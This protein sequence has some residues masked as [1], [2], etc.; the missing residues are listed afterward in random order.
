M[1]RTT[2]KIS[3]LWTPLALLIGMFSSACVVAAPPEMV[4]VSA[5][6]QP[7]GPAYTFNYSKYL[8]TNNE[9]ARFLNDAEANQ[10]SDKGANMI[11][12]ATGNVGFG[13]DTDDGLYRRSATGDLDYNPGMPLGSRYSVT[14]GNEQMPVHAVSWFGAMKYCN[15]LTLDEGWGETQRAYHEGAGEFD[16]YP[17]HL[18]QANWLDGFSNA[19]RADWCQLSG[20]RLPMDH[21]SVGASAY[22][23]FYKA[24]AWNGTANATYGWGRNTRTG[25]DGNYW[26]SGDPWV[27]GGNSYQQRTPVGFYDGSLQ[28]KSTWNW[29]DAMATFQ[30]N[31]NGNAWGIHDMSGNEWKWTADTLSEGDFS[32]LANRYIV[33]RGQGN[34]SG[35]P[36][37]TVRNPQDPFNLYA[38]VSFHIVQ[39]P[40]EIQGEYCGMFG[41]VYLDA[42]QTGPNDVP[43]CYVDHYDLAL[44]FEQWQLCTDP[45]DANCI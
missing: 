4:V 9:W 18:T 11:F 12:G 13:A 5:G 30:T 40:G 14:A 44:L 35:D 6:G 33:V 7:G 41:T 43:D 34:S 39:I 10:G 15:W 25:A 31:V 29:P 20:Y 45:V 37:L 36:T 8:I 24:G 26:E 22:N 19:E 21:Y 16:W 3:L 27:A 17:A 38:T 23:E 28:Q 1:N 2:S 42:D 32:E